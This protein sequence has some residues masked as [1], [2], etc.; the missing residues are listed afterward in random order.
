M[1]MRR[2]EERGLVD[3]ASA[4]GGKPSKEGDDDAAEAKL[5]RGGGGRRPPPAARRVVRVNNKGFTT[6]SKGDRNDEGSD[7]D[8]N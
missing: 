6:I 5:W 3:E 7:Y 8:K 4:R 1:R 2:K